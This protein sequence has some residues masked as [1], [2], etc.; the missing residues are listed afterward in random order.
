MEFDGFNQQQQQMQQQPRTQQQVSRFSQ[1][2]TAIQEE[3]KKHEDPEKV[4]LEDDD[5]VLPL[6]VS[7]DLVR[8]QRDY[9]KT[10][11][12]KLQ[13]MMN[14]HR[15]L[16]SKMKDQYTILQKGWFREKQYAKR[17][18]A[19]DRYVKE[20]ADRPKTEQ[21][22][23]KNKNKTNRAKKNKSQITK[24]ASKDKEEASVGI[25][26]REMANSQELVN[27]QEINLS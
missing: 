6:K 25:L 20:R 5:F 12:Q 7:K 9:N 23:N 19:Y 13:K 11:K 21:K 17:N 1:V 16:L 3:M 10:H 8:N 24:K 18:L 15:T 27:S 2:L 14:K 26:T 22:Q 4:E